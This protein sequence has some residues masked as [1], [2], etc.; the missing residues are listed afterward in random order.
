MRAQCKLFYRVVVLVCLCSGVVEDALAQDRAPGEIQL[1]SPLRIEHVVRLARAGRAEII[2]ARAAALAAAQRPA[3]VSALEDPVVSPAV[4]HLPFMLHGADFSLSIEQRF[5]LSRVLGNRGRAAEADTARLRAEAVRVGLDVELDAVNAFLM[6][7]ERRQMAVFIEEQLVLAVQFV[8]ATNARY[9]SGNGAQPDVLR[10]E[11][12]VARLEGA[13]RSIRSEVR[14]AEAMLNTS[15]ARAPDAELPPL[16]GTA[17]T[18][19]PPEWSALREAAL[20]GRPELS[21]GRAEIRKA[22]AEVT[23]MQSMDSPMAMVRTGPAYTMTDGFGWMLMV[24]VSVPIWRDRIKSGV[25]EAEAM[26]AMSRAD[27]SAMSRMVEGEAAASRHRVLAARDRYLALRDEILPRARRVIGPSLAGYSAGT[28]PLV[29][30]IESA[31]ALWST[32]AELVSAELELGLAWARLN[33]AIAG[34]GPRP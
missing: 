15:L 23:V 24:G 33:R 9:A 22:Q 2:A 8:G 14:A 11:I 16:E 21:S 19:V 28:L 34:G 6:V 26:V 25:R 18:T 31:Q 12:E 10:S 20:H 30:V 7:H 13:L 29:S 5:P 4:D 3:I 32:E 27:L 1:P 17:R